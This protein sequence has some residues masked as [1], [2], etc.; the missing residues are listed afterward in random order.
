MNLF[1]LHQFHKSASKV[2]KIQ[3]VITSEFFKNP[4][5]LVTTTLQNSNLERSLNKSK[6]SLKINKQAKSQYS[7]EQGTSKVVKDSQSLTK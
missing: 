7:V 3:Q 2:K 6:K 4:L 1:E 5:G